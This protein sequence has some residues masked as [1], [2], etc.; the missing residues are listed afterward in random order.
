MAI[1]QPNYYIHLAVW[2]RIGKVRRSRPA[3]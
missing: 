2:R 3:F 1:H